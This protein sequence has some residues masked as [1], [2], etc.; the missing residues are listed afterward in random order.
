MKT[1]TQ[2]LAAIGIPVIAMTGWL[3]YSVYAAQAKPG[4][5]LA[6]APMNTQVQVP[7]AFIMAVDDSGSM[8]FHN[9]FP[10]NDG[11]ACWS[12]SSFFESAGVMRTTGTCTFSY[13]YTG[14]RIGTSYLGIPPV[15]THGFARSPDFNPSYFDPEITYL[16]WLNADGSPYG[17]V[18]SRPDGDADLNNTRIDPR[19]NDTIS[20]P[21]NFNEVAERSRFNTRNGMFLPAGTEYRLDG[22]NNA[23]CGGL[24]NGGNSSW[25][26]V[27]SGGHTM[28]A[29]CVIYIAYWPATFFLRETVANTAPTISAP[30]YSGITPVR[31]QDACGTG[32]HMWKYTIPR[33]G[34]DTR[35]LQNFANWY[36]FY[37]N[38]NR[39]MV[40]GMTRSMATVNN[41]RVG[42][43]TINSHGSYDNPVGS[44]SERVWMRDMA[45]DADRTA[46]W[47]NMLALPA[48]GG[49]PNRQAVYAAGE[50]FRRA[51]T[52][53]DRGGPPV[54]L[55]CQRNALMLFTDGFSNNNGPA[56]GN[57]DGS[58]LAP[59]RDGHSDT[60]ADI[61]TR[62]YVDNSG[63]S[64]IRPDMQAGQVPVPSTCP[65][66]DPRVN[67]QKNLHVNFY[68][69]TLGGRGNLY[70]PDNPADAYTTAAV[71]NNWPSRQNDNRSTID[72]IWHAAVNTRGEFINARTP[73]DIVNAMRRILGNVT[74]G[75]TP[76]GTLAL[77][78]ARIGTG[79]LGV[80]PGYEVKNEGTDWLGTLSAYRPSIGSDGKVSQVEAWQANFPAHTARTSQTFFARGNSVLPFTSANVGLADLCG[81]PVDRYPGMARCSVSELTALGATDA[82]AVR[83]LMGD[84]S[85]ERRN[86]GPFRDRSSLL[87][88]IVN[89]T[90]VV[91]SPRDD[92]GYRSIAGNIGSSYAGYLTAKGS[93]PYMVYV[94]A[95]DGMLHAFHGGM[96]AAGDV[97]SGGGREQFA[98]IPAT[99]I[100]HMGNL[101]FPYN[102]ANGGDQ[103]FDHRYFVDGPISVSDVCG[104][105][106]TAAA[107]W[108]TV[109]VGTSG[110]GGRSVFA[111]NVSNPT[112]F[113]VAD[114][115][116][117]ISDVN[118]NLT[119]SVRNN[120]GFVLGRPVIVPVKTGA[121]VS[122]KAIFGNGYNS[123]SG[124]AV[125]F[126]VDLSS[127]FSASSIRMI[128]AEESGAPSGKNGLGNIVV[129]DRVG[130]LG[131]V[132]DGYADVVYAA[133][134]K[135]AIWKF[136]L[137]DSA[138]TKL[139]VPF[140]TSRSFVESGVTQRQPI[141][142]GLTAATGPGGGVMLYFGTGSFSFVGD[143]TDATA[144]S[145][146]AVNDTVAGPITGTTTRTHLVARTVNAGAN[147]ERTLGNPSTVVGARGWYVDLPAGER[148]VGNP[149]IASG[150]V[151]M[152]TYS[153]QVGAGGCA[154]T[155]LNWLFG[156]NAR[157][158]AAALSNVRRGGP[159]GDMPAAGT[160]SLQLNTPGTA[161]VKD[162][163][164][165]VLPRIGPPVPDP[166]LPPGTPPATP[167]S[168]PAQGC[169]M[170]VTT[171]GLAEGLYLPYPC[172]R[173]SWRQVQ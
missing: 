31:V 71:Y 38:R 72:D 86:T 169:W 73:V 110:A 118:T 95:N 37:G 88:D 10:G 162:V 25:K 60:M 82:N 22:N 154:T 63:Q 3:A 130:A 123:E 160:A 137:H 28:T 5:P 136:D 142:G 59:F 115:M 65:S 101:L 42:Y 33:G 140:F 13:S 11:Y 172:G 98:Y 47:T 6:Q 55:A 109:L 113:A 64:P 128:E 17:A 84:V 165:T 157:S 68:G 58:L 97:V 158:G 83:Y 168:P 85:L 15:D 70:D 39:A 131:A 29:N 173:Q 126:V 121:N 159:N 138:N 93:R 117:E 53:N 56:V 144:Q 27:G 90:P 167:P 35:A 30:G 92:Y 127:S 163:G 54:K 32:C 81:T 111:L 75:A 166:T 146:Y 34:S 4:A 148:F 74:G 103:K 50:Q 143:A 2:I 52:N 8:T 105:T 9:Q 122:W 133:D 125:L 170:A 16:P 108:K 112:G 43:F 49:T 94:G 48:S 147:G 21:S 114:R 153:P 99:S 107:H 116:W 129:V 135:G 155:G 145:L 24:S 134:Q 46:L 119:T 156:L 120:I 151:F 26:T 164:V 87:G 69:V 1:S 102:P 76:S 149:R 18:P 132:R 62:L 161:P 7:P 171:A 20:L 77:T 66:S 78:G 150:V 57:V 139:T 124:K 23:S 79:S 80:E 152:P 12:G 91:S 104:T 106:C 51:E 89:S 61:V 19:V 44:A 67:C 41:M 96:N 40:A 36:S 14:P 45:V 100:G 141:I